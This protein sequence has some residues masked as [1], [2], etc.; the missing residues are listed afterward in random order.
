M[1][2]RDNLGLQFTKKEDREQFYIKKVKK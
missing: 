2:V 1:T